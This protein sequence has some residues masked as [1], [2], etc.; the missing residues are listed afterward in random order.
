V[1]VVIVGN[2]FTECGHHEGRLKE[3]RWCQ[4]DIQERGG[5]PMDVVVDVALGSMVLVVAVQVFVAAV[6][7]AFAMYLE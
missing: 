7:V 1:V 5:I 3:T 6:I 2:L 4:Q